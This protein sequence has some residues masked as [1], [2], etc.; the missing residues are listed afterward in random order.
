MPYCFINTWVNTGISKP[1]GYDEKMVKA[2]FDKEQYN[3][4]GTMKLVET[5]EDEKHPNIL[6]LQLES[7]VDPSLFNN[8][9]TFAGCSA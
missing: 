5:D 6:F 8:I 3:E 7:F 4:D 1:N 2:I 9:G